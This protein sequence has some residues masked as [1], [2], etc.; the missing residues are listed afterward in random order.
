MILLEKVLE[1]EDIQRGLKSVFGRLHAGDSKSFDNAIDFSRAAIKVLTRYYYN[2]PAALRDVALP[3]NLYILEVVA[4][5]WES[6]TIGLSEKPSR[7]TSGKKKT[8]E[9]LKEEWDAKQGGGKKYNVPLALMGADQFAKFACEVF[10]NALVVRMNL[11]LK[12]RSD[13]MKM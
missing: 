12:A 3:P 1:R 10:K 6:G 5:M 11:L 7:P 4:R 2:S 9:E 13:R 8:K